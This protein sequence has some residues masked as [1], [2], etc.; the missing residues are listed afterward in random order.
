M[1]TIALF[2]KVKIS[3]YLFYFIILFTGIYFIISI[4]FNNRTAPLFSVNKNSSALLTPVTGKKIA[5]IIVGHGGF[6]NDF[7]KMKEYMQLAEKGGEK[8]EKI[9][10]EMI[11]WPR[12][13][14]NDSYWAGIMKIAKEIEGKKTF[15]LVK[16]AFNEYCTP[17]V[18]E[19]LTEVVKE[20]PDEIIVTSIMMTSGGAHSEHDIPGSIK[21]FKEKNPN[22]KITY[23]WP[24]EPSEISE[25]LISHSQKFISK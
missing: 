8:F 11:H 2:S 10:N 12:N 23:A 13:E 25:F 5:L 1:K 17:T 7:P 21:S 14:N 19:A 24:Y 4:V 6:P 15:S 20:N 3:S 9:E 16:V 22:V 18:T